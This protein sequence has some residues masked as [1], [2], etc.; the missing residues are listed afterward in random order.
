MLFTSIK[1]ML[2]SMGSEIHNDL[3]NLYDIKWDGWRILL[4]KQGNRIEAYTR[5]GNRVTD[6]FPELEQIVPHIK[7]EI[8]ILDCEGVV[9]RDG[10]SVFEDFQYRG[11]LRSNH[12]IES[13]MVSHPVTFVAF[14]VLA[15]EKPLL[16]LPLYERK[17]ILSDI[18]I[19]S[20]QIVPTP[21]IIEDGESLFQITKEKGMEGIVAKPLSSI[22][23]V[24]V[25][26]AEWLKYKHFKRMKTIIL[27]Y[28][29]NPFS[30]I[31]GMKQNGNITPVAQVEF[32]FSIEEKQAFRNIAKEIITNKADNVY[33]IDPV[34]CCEVQYLE[35]TENQK[36]RI[37]SFKGFAFDVKPEEC[38]I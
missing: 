31:V 19:P 22:Y 4:H 9:I 21:Y 14:D 8:A 29:E 28:K 33:W 5:H 32:G 35:K 2:L 13:A 36:L 15:T 3:N 34:L 1:P 23:Q 17:Q 20:N 37:V 26:S 7:T 38:A 12:K 11:R 10:V 18:I 24:G 27:G 6:Q 25:R 16:K 30:M